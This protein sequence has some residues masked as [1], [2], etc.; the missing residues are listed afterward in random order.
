MADPNSS[1]AKGRAQEALE[2]VVG[3]LGA[4]GGTLHLFGDDGML[5]LQAYAP[6]M[7]EQV[8]SIIRAIPVGK[9]M[10]GRAVE[11][12]RPIDTCNIA[13]DDS[14]D[15]RPGAKMTG[16]K[17]AVAV[18]VYRGEEIVGALGVGNQEERTFTQEETDRL[19]AVGRNIAE[20]LADRPT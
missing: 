11:A 20:T 10:A 12:A 13:T 15:V 19:L 14:G 3:E 6:D 16:L 1:S 7:P 2:S 17:G 9:G 8:L 4:D 18:P 5:H